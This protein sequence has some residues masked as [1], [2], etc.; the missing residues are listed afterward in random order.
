MKQLQFKSATANL[1]ETEGVCLVVFVAETAERITMKRM[2]IFVIV[3]YKL[4]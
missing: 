1:G 2:H 3:V 4:K